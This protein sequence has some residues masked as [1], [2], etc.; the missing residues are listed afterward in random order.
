MKLIIKEYLAALRER[1]E[2]DAILPDLLSQLGL[3]VYS[4]PARGTRQ[5]GVD[6]GAVGSLDGGSEKV[7]LFSIK[8]GDLTRRGWDGDSAQS[9]RPSLNEILDSYISTR[10]PSEH[11]DKEIVVCVAIGGDVQ[12][13]VRPLLTGYFVQN[14]KAN[15]TFEE[16][17]GDKLAALIQS[18]FLREDLLPAHARSLLRKALAMLDEPQVSYRHFSVLIRALAEANERQDEQCLTALRQMSICLWILFAWAREASNMESAYLGGELTLLH[19]WNIVR[20]YVGGN[21]KTTRAIETAFFSIFT[22]YQQIC[23]EFLGQN[24]LPHAHQLHALSDA[25]HSSCNLDVNLKLFDVLGRLALGGIWA[26]WGARRRADGEDAQRDARLREAHRYAEAVQELISN[27]PVL[28]LPAKDDQAIDIQIAAL[29]LG[30]DSSRRNF[31]KSWLK[32]VLDR[33]YFS[34][35]VNG[36]YPCVL[37]SYSDLLEH[38]KS[39]DS[40]YR[41]KATSAS[42]LYPSIALWAALLNDDATYTRVASLKR[43]LLP[44]CTFQFWYPDDRSEASFYTDAE[45]HGAALAELAVERPKEEFL[46]QVFVE[47]ERT[48]HLTEL[49]AVKSGWW[50]LIAVACRHYRLPLPIHFLEGL[51]SPPSEP[52]SLAV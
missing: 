32:E 4:R 29:L 6:V 35:R 28:M 17:N 8:P 16:W 46:A 30:I 36:R 39:T 37:Q 42:I 31:L 41:E 52:D 3:N 9:L 34:T 10:L 44:H 51:R 43:E 7:Y 1:G 27:N 22:A 33:A 48:P 2:L 26:Y 15:V 24:V 19:A 12:E 23:S 25:V 21:N 50:P 20:L 49:S 5:D 45:S 38:P 13:Q 18:S 40:E 47:C 14:S 11:R